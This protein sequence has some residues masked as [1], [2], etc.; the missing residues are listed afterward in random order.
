MDNDNATTAIKP[1]VTFNIGRNKRKA[2]LR[3]IWKAKRAAAV[4]QAAH[5]QLTMRNTAP[6]LKV[7]K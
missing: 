3:K 4:A 2:T 7:Y 6:K 5:I 1:V